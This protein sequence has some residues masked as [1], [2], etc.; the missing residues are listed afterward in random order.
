M[1][2]KPISMDTLHSQSWKFWAPI[3][4]SAWKCYSTT[5]RS[6]SRG[7]SGIVLRVLASRVS[8]YLLDSLV[9]EKY[10]ILGIKTPRCWYVIFI[11]TYSKLNF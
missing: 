4:L 11:N 2:A 7:K 5:V 1:L 6:E 10:L 9:H 3:L 8:G